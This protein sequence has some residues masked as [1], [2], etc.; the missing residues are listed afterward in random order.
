[1]ELD[2]E[3]KPRKNAFYHIQLLVT[4]KAAEKTWNESEKVDRVTALRMFTRWAAEYV[5]KENVIGSIEPGKWAD[6]IVVDR[7]YMAVPEAEIGKIQVLLTL[8]G[9]K[10]VYQDSIV[11]AAERLGRRFLDVLRSFWTTAETAEAKH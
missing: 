5:L 1:M 10:I 4:R 3:L 6:L 7:D 9:G 8:V 11:T 2:T